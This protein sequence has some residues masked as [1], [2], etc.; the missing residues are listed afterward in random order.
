MEDDKK[1]TQM[2]GPVAAVAITVLIYI[3]AQILGVILFVTGYA[4]YHTILKYG[5]SLSHFGESFRAL[6]H[7]PGS[8]GHGSYAMFFEILAIELITLYLVYLFLNWRKLSFRSLGLNQPAVKHI[9]YALSGFALYF[10]LYIVVL[11]IAKQ[12]IPSL[13]FDQKQ[14]LGFEPSNTQALLPVFISLVVLPPITEE[15]VVRGFLFGG[16]RTKL[17]FITSA[18]ITSLLFAAAHLS[19][20]GSGAGLLWVAGIDTFVLSMVLCYLREK[21]GSLWPSIGVHMLK[22]GLAFVVLFNVF[23]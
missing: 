2:Y 15:I 3:A 17:P 7:D 20:G 23:R 1:Q 4:A 18:V 16:L 12:L 8:I 5:V 14:D 11:I 13:N 21:T 19:E 10:L 22:N 6:A 9:A